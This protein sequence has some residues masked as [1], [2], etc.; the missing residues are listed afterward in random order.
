MEQGGDLAHK[1]HDNS[2]D[3]CTCNDID[4]V[5]FIKRHN[6][7]ILS[8]A[9]HWWCSEKPRNNLSQTITSQ[10]LVQSWILE[11]IL[12]CQ[13]IQY[14][15]MSEMFCHGYKGDRRHS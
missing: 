8:V 5:D 4:A 2:Q 7:D 10:G 13:A 12:A 6:S 14:H 11:E 9:S 3:C 1:A 15:D